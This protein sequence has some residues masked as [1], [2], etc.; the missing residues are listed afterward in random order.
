MRLQLLIPAAAAIAFAVCGVTVAI[1][2]D[3]S[4]NTGRD[5][6]ATCTNCHGTDGRSRGAIPAIA[7][8]DK[9]YLVQQL[10]D[11]RDGKRPSTIMQQLAKGYSDAQIDAAA[12]YLASQKPN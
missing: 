10:K 8:Q 5:I 12:A 4:A 6:A 11:F 2:A 3:A 9:A 7:G 1:G